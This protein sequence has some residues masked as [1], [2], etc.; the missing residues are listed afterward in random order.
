MFDNLLYIRNYIADRAPEKVLWIRTPL[1]PG[2]TASCDNITGIG[3][4]IAQNLAGIVQRWELC[5]FN[6]L[7]QDKYRRLGLAWQ[8]VDT[9][10]MTKSALCEMEQYAK[11]SGVDPE[12]VIATGATKMEDS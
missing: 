12:I 1:I 11:L 3:A 10:L 6:N 4:F 5:A 9:P 8:Y 2:A 7:C